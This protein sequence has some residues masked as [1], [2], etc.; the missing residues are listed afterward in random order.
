MGAAHILELVLGNIEDDSSLRS[1]D[2]RL[3]QLA[4]KIKENKDKSSHVRSVLLTVWSCKVG[5]AMSRAEY[6]CMD[7][8]CDVLESLRN[9][10]YDVLESLCNEGSG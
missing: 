5:R 10:V 4:N 7:V 2:A 3:A 6:V 1:L 9:E 8:V